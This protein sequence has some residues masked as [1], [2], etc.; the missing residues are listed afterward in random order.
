MG[1]GPRP[2]Q[3]RTQVTASCSPPLPAHMG[4]LRNTGTGQRNLTGTTSKVCEQSGA[5]KD[6]VAQAGLCKPPEARGFRAL[7]KPGSLWW[8]TWGRW[9]AEPERLGLAQ[10]GGVEGREEVAVHHTTWPRTRRAGLALKPPL[11]GQGEL[12]GGGSRQPPRVPDR[13]RMGAPPQQPQGLWGGGSPA[14]PAGPC[15]PS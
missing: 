11:C 3:S 12:G 5:V 15:P 13:G 4:Q 14:G 9:P 8:P 10:V 1:P 6:R 7:W 2:K